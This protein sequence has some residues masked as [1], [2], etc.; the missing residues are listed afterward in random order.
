[1]EV[2]SKKPSFLSRLKSTLDKD[3][4]ARLPQKKQPI[5]SPAG[6]LPQELAEYIINHLW[7]H[8]DSLLACCLTCKAWVE[9]SRY[10]LF[11]RRKLLY[12]HQYKSLMI[13]RRYELIGYIRRI[14]LDLLPPFTN[15]S[16]TFRY[17]KDMGPA[18]SL[19]ALALTDYHVFYL[20]ESTRLAQAAPL[21]VTLELINPEGSPSDILQF[22]CLFPNLDNLLV[23]KH[24]EKGTKPIPHYGT[25]PSFRG[26]LTLKYMNCV[27]EEG[28]LR[29]LE[30]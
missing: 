29:S 25:S 17:L 22:I 6:R 21:L 19:H 16:P 9:P 10:H 30:D 13:L 8:F 15:K 4:R 23:V 20:P 26:V 7:Y 27:G 12:E 1:M 18:T 11:Y 28:F 3:I 2:D 24:S 14:E 5:Q